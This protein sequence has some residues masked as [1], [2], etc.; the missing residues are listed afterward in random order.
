MKTIV[1][2]FAASVLL[3]TVPASDNDKAFVGKVSQGGAYEVEASKFAVLHAAAQDVK[4]QA[5]AEVHDD[6]LVG[7][8]LKRLSAADGIPIRRPPC[9][10]ESRRRLRLRRRLH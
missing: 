1:S 2:A 6:E 7:A 4:D 8:N 10:A 9:E 5:I 3:V